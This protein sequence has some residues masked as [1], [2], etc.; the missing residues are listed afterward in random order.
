MSIFLNGLKKEICAEMKV[1][2]FRNSSAMMNLAFGV[3]GKKFSVEGYRGESGPKT[4]GWAFTWDWP[5]LTPKLDP[6]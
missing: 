5:N 6:Q 2:A 3:R 4:C 1:E